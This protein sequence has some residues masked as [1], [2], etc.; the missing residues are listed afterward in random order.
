MVGQPD[1]PLGDLG[2]FISLAPQ[3]PCT[4]LSPAEKTGWSG[5]AGGTCGPQGATG[6]WARRSLG[7]QP[8]SPHVPPGPTGHFS[9]GLADVEVERGEA[10]VL[11]C[12]L[13][14]DLGP[15]AWFKDGVKVLPSLTLLPPLYQAACAG[16][17]SEAEGQTAAALQERDFTLCCNSA[18]SAKFTWLTTWRVWKGLSLGGPVFRSVLLRQASGPPATIQPAFL[19]Q[20]LLT[21]VLRALDSL[22]SPHPLL[23][24]RWGWPRALE[25]S[26]ILSWFLGQQCHPPHRSLDG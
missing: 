6:S 24:S 26:F 15:G 13:I 21:S 3:T 23:T 12:T 7:T 19:S 1:V 4:S 16:G 20:H 5:P 25:L 22:S 10:A 9:Q 2:P 14:R 8:P 17:L 18:D 11:S